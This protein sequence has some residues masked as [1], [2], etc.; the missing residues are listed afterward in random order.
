MQNFWIYSIAI[1]VLLSGVNYLCHNCLDASYAKIL[2]ILAYLVIAFIIF[3]SIRWNN[4]K[5]DSSNETQSQI[6]IKNMV[7]TLLAII[8][9]ILLYCKLTK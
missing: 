1:I 2:S 3:S 8:V 5:D 4:S 9:I 6:M 7:D